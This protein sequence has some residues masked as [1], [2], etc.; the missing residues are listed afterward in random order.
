[1][2]KTIVFF[3]ETLWDAPL[4]ISTNAIARV[5][6]AK[7]WKCA[8]IV[9]PLSVYDLCR[10]SHRRKLELFLSGGVWHEQN[11]FEYCPL[12]LARIGR[13]WPLK[14]AWVGGNA[15]RLTMPSLK[16][17]LKKNGFLPAD[18]LMI[19][20]RAAASALGYLP[21]KHVIYHAQDYFARRLDQSPALDAAERL[22]IQRSDLVMPVQD[23]HASRFV[24]ELDV[25]PEKMEVLHL[26]AD[27]DVFSARVAEPVDL[28]SIPHPRIAVVGTLATMDRDMLLKVATSLRAMHFVSIGPRDASWERE[29]ARQKASNIHFIGAR[30]YEQLPGYLRH[31]DVGLAM[32]RVADVGTRIVG[33]FYMKIYDYAAASLPIVVTEM[34][35]Y[36]NV[37]DFMFCAKTVDEFVGALQRALCYTQ[38]QFDRL[39]RFSSESGSWQSRYQQIIDALDR[40]AARP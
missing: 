39:R 18:V 5:F 17:I 37:R 21:A 22:L 23:V 28:K 8:W 29:A 24:Q 32:Y 2:S 14:T 19:G 30:D 11:V 12:S 1:M 25:P 13:V 16:H 27:T 3:R 9:N 10:P 4:R 15:L 34:P 35:G 6:A 38:E 31:C 33:G 20:S 7:G 36:E 40:L 26:A